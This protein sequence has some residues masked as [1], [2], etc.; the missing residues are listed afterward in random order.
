[1]EKRLLLF[2]AIFVAL[3][4]ANILLDPRQP[5][6]PPADPADGQAAAVD[7]KAAKEKGDDQDR[8]AGDG[9]SGAKLADSEQAP[10]G[11]Q[12]ADDADDEKV[13]G[14]A[15]LP[16]AKQVPESWVTLGSLDPGPGNPYR[17]LVT[18]TNRGAAVR[19]LELSRPKYRDLEDRSGYLGSLAAVE[20][21]GGCRIR[22]VGRGTPAEAAGLLPGDVIRSIDDQ[23]ILEPEDLRRLLSRTEPG[24]TVDIG[25]ARGDGDAAKT[26]TVQATLMRRPLAIMRP[27][28]E[29]L[30]MRRA[31]AP[32]DF[33][34][35][36]SLLMTLQ[37]IG[38]QKLD[39]DASRL[40]GHELA[41]V[42]L[43]S[44]NWEIAE[45]SETSVT[46]RHVL[47]SHKLE[48]SKTLRLVKVPTEH[49]EDADY[50]GYH[51]EV[52]LAVRNL[53]EQP[54]QVA[55][56]LD[57]PTGL[58]IEGWWYASKI[59]RSMFG[60]AG[61]RDVVGRWEGNQPS[62]FPI[63]D[64]AEGE[65]EPKVDHSM[66]Y[67]G[68]DAQYF[69]AVLLPQKASESEIWL[70]ESRFVTVGPVEENSRLTNVTCQLF[71]KASTLA[72]GETFEHKYV[73]FAGPKRADLVRQYH[74]PSAPGYSLGDLIYFGWFGWVAQIMLAVLHT[75]YGFVG[76]YGI[77]IIVLTVLVR[78]C[79]FPLSR[80][81]A[82]N[83]IKMQELQ[84]EI[85]KLQE[86]YKNDMEKR[87]KAQQDLF[88]KHNY[89]PM[90]GCL[91]MFVQLPIFIG[92]YRSLMVD[93]ELRQAP[94]IS[95]SI[96]WCSNLA[97]PDMLFDWSS[98]MPGFIT[99]GEGF[100]G[101]GPY[102]NVLPLVTVGLFL[103][104][105]KKF[106]PP[107]TD[108]Q[109]ALQQKVMSFMTIFIGLLFYKVAA[110]LCIYFIASTIWGI[111]ERTQLPKAKT[112]TQDAANAGE[113][114][115]S[116]AAEARKAA[117]S[118]SGPNGTSGTAG[119]KKQKRR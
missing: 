44:A 9:K 48:V 103:A 38:E 100:F 12:G 83:M 70:R 29:N 116:K 11:D 24:Q 96:R 13:A 28:V 17:M 22:V 46:F 18:L 15:P 40:F 33:S 42:D 93:V 69:S 91:L 39:K 79:M 61:L 41:D 27:E 23:T 14:E 68:V 97:A 54:Q 86:K 19:R 58:P 117:R 84:P 82:L 87:T 115:A 30:R 98:F 94:L 47:P 31:G 80:K 63:S 109:Q 6:P 51:L 67:L 118:K 20:A 34:D 108:E 114:G 119:R 52:D 101:L 106:M 3:M 49:L 5:A 59:G 62:M 72:A 21:G 104:Q 105:Q 88:R 4:A 75:V 92:L 35:P 77:A 55:Y 50:P 64:I 112:P 78:G 45:R 37:S 81:Q 26:Q 66:M 71:S 60:G 32:P 36:P 25:L 73:L 1:V 65:A 10:A 57:G 56:R 110:G 74:P 53:A 99:S 8:Q 113:Q 102:F 90:G 95:D 89:N 107:P 2:F 85:K 7:D 16:P 76:N 43:H 111:V